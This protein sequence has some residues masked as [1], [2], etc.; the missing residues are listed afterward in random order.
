[1]DGGGGRPGVDLIG[2]GRRGRSFTLAGRGGRGGSEEFVLAGLVVSALVWTTGP[3]LRA[4][5]GAGAGGLDEAGTGPGP[6]G[7]GAIAGAAVVGLAA[8]TGFGCGGV[9]EAP[10]GF[11]ARVGALPLR[12]EVSAAGLVG[13]PGRTLAT[14]TV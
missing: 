2:G 14:L 6:A 12:G 11:G 3:F 4:G 5:A 7:L 8:G 9:G 13:M 1:M 10:V